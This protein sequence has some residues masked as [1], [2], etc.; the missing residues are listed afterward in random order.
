MVGKIEKMMLELVESQEFR[1][2]LTA[3]VLR[4]FGADLSEVPND[5]DESTKE[6]LP[7]NPNTNLTPEGLGWHFRQKLARR[8]N[9]QESLEDCTAH[10]AAL[11]AKGV[12]PEMVLEKLKGRGRHVE[13]I[14]DFL[15]RFAGEEQSK[16]GS[17]SLKAAMG[18][19]A[20]TK[21]M[22]EARKHVVPTC[23]R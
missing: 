4:H 20:A 5:D 8:P 7:E 1:S 6:T 23:S 17:E 16:C 21:Q 9:S 14:W 19:V 13:P 18:R 2:L 10:F 12:S 15:K 3:A 11:L 22:I